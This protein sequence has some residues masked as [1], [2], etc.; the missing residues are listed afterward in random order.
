[1]VIKKQFKK[2]LIKFIRIQIISHSSALLVDNLRKMDCS[3]YCMQIVLS[4]RR[5][6]VLTC[7]E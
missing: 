2:L 6:D 5:P 1:M 3:L 4:R 7:T